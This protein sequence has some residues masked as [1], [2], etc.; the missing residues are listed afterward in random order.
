MA[1]PAGIDVII[2]T[3][4]LG[5]L[6]AHIRFD[7][8][9]FARLDLPTG[10]PGEFVTPLT[11]VLGTP[12]A[13]TDATQPRPD[14]EYTGRSP[15]GGATIC[16]VRSRV[17]HCVSGVW[18]HTTASHGVERVEMCTP[19][20]F[21]SGQTSTEGVFR[22]NLTELAERA[23]PE[24]ATRPT[25]TS[26]ATPEGPRV[27]TLQA[28]VQ[29]D[30]TGPE[31]EGHRDAL[32]RDPQFRRVW[33]VPRGQ[34]AGAIGNTQPMRIIADP[35][36]PT[37]RSRRYPTPKRMLPVLT[38]W[39]RDMLQRQL[40]E[41]TFTAT[42]TAAIFAVPKPRSPGEWRVVVD[43]REV[44]QSLADLSQH[45]MPDAAELLTTCEH[46]QYTSALD[47][48]DGYYSLALHPDDRDLTAFT[49]NGRTYRYTVA[50][51][52][53][54]QTP[55]QFQNMVNRCLRN[56]DLLGTTLNDGSP[57]PLRNGEQLERNG[58]V[59]SARGVVAYIDDLLKPLDSMRK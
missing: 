38:T 55:V 18:E 31:A 54:S 41:P 37:P 2:G 58:R 44:N 24:G 42:S 59:I 39:A 4:A 1:L 16:A 36:K 46:A 10:A 52:G 40:I 50:P 21:W 15:E 12:R 32:Q 28:G 6:Q 8:S 33:E 48:K 20:Q 19:R 29:I 47:L 45:N 9:S 43:L 7:G 34:P 49:V 3:K 30:A 22:I 14:I 11:T 51:M 53:C 57:R 5:E 25:P 35:A 17:E 56:Y 26:S 23:G 27:A 13:H